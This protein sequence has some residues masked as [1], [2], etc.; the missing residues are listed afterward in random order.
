MKF[1]LSVRFPLIIICVAACTLNVACQFTRASE[2]AIE[3]ERDCNRPVTFSSP[4]YDKASVQEE[5]ER[6]S[7]DYPKKVLG[8]ASAIG[9]LPELTQLTEI[10][11][12]AAYEREGYGTPVLKPQYQLLSR[13]MLIMLEVN[14]SVA[15]AR[16]KEARIKEIVDHLQRA[17]NRQTGVL[18]LIS[19]ITGGIGGALSGAFALAHNLVAD[20]TSAIAGGAL[21]TTGGVSAFLLDTQYELKHS[22]NILKEI[23]EGPEKSKMFPPS[24]WHFLTFP[25]RDQGTPRENLVDKWKKK[26]GI[27]EKGSQE[28]EERAS[29]LFSKGGTYELSDLR[30]RATMLDL[31]ASTIELMHQDIEELIRGIWDRVNNAEPAPA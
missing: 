6:V 12:Q 15:E 27:S 11:N 22:R 8:L 9:L 14:S 17:E 31:L 4:A 2:P 13:V 5:L 20:A 25:R 1:S 21:T 28:E 18:T 30:A 7:Q 24:V 29:L 26:V 16:C 3:E 10:Q 19:V 23:W